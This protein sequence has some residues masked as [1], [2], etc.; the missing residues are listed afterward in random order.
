MQGANITIKGAAKS[1]ATD[2]DGVF[3]IHVP[4]ESVLIISMVGYKKQEY[5]VREEQANLI[6]S[7]QEDLKV[8]D[9]VVVTGFGSQKVKNIASSVST[10][11]MGNVKNKPVVQLSQAL[12]GGATGIQVSQTTGLVGSDQANIRIRGVGTLLNAAPLVMVDGVPFDMNNLD[13]NTIESVTVLKDAAAASMYGA[14]GGNGVIIITTKRGVAGVPSMEY[15][16]FYG[17]QRPQYMPDFVDA[18]TWMRMNNEAMTNSGGN[19][20]YSDADIATTKDGSDPVKYPNTNWPDLVLR[21]SI[22]IQQHSIQVS[23]GN[24]AA[25]FALSLNQT[26]QKGHVRNSDYGR[27]TLRANTTVDLLKNFFIYMDIFASAPV[28]I[29]PMPVTVSPQIFTGGCIRCL[30]ILIPNTRIRQKILVIPIMVFMEKAG[31]P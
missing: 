4:K 27:T 22:P 6:V 10:V 5:L 12:Q 31:T 2:I 13:P 24:T 28:R 20:I 7:L 14:R 18:S 11:N 17:I 25:R 19:P 3:Q 1:V 8:L 23:G 15:N 16:G 30:Q 29:N 21:K 26:T 9:Q